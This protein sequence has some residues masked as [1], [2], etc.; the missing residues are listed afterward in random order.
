[1]TRAHDSQYKPPADPYASQRC[2]CKH[3]RYANAPYWTPL[4]GNCP[5]PL[6]RCEDHRPVGVTVGGDAK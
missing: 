5:W 4:G 2:K 3:F 6:C 1:M